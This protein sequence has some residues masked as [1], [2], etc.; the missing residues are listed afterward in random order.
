MVK[1]IKDL[2][3]QRYRETFGRY[4]EDFEIGDI[5]EHRP[6]RTITQ[7]D[8]TWFTLLTMNTHPLHFDEEY[9]KAT[10]FGKTLV[11]STFTVAVMVG[12]SVSDVSQKAIA[13]LGWTD[14]VLPNPLFEGDTLYA[15]SEVLE[16]RLSK[17]RENCG[18]VTVKTTGTN[19][20]GVIVAT[21]KRSALIP[22]TGNAVDDKTNY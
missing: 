20:D 7:S 10:E 16:K 8:N 9:G 19:Q 17:S 3:N 5:Y 21:Y 22:T 13:N 14:I 15:E 18:I 1:G 11:N 6:G 4:F 2:G 12:M